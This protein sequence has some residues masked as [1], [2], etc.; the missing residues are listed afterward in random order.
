MPLSSKIVLSS[1]F[2]SATLISTFLDSFLL[3]DFSSLFFAV[4]VPVFSNNQRTTNKI[5]AIER[6]HCIASHER[7]AGEST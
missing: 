2:S 5:E 7:R 4:P 3:W 6:S 1:P